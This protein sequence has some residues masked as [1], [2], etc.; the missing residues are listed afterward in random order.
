MKDKVIAVLTR[1]DALRVTEGEGIPSR[2]EFAAYLHDV[3][4]KAELYDAL[5]ARVAALE[6]A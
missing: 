5:A 4:S 1:N 6:K 2:A 3:F